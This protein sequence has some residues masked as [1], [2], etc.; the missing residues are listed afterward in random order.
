[1]SD[2]FVHPGRLEGCIRIPPSKSMAHRAVICSMLAG[3]TSLSG[4][5]TGAGDLGAAALS[6]DIHTTIEAMRCLLAGKKEISCDESGSTLRFLIPIAAALGKNVTFTGAGRLPD[7]PLHEYLAIFEDKGISLKFPEDGRSLPLSVKGQL[8]AGHFRVPG[9]VSSQYITGLLLALPLLDGDSEI[10]V[11]SFLESAGYVDM[12]LQVM[13][14]FGVAA[15]NVKNSYLIHGGQKYY[16]SSYNIEGDYSQAAFW[17]TANYLGS[18]VTLSGLDDASAQGDRDIIWFLEI[19]RNARIDAGKIGSEQADRKKAD[20]K[21]ADRKQTGGEQ[22]GVKQTGSDQTG[23]EIEIDASQ[24]PDLVPIIAVAA[25]NTDATTKIV[26]AGRLRYKESDRLKS[27]AQMIS[28]IGGDITETSDGLLIRGGRRMTGGTAD[29]YGD[30]RISMAAAI[31]A[32]STL[33]GVT[34]INYNCVD[35]SYPTFFDEFKK[36]GGVLN[37]LDLGKQS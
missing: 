7:R 37:E 25:A 33:N 12:T 18:D 22:T 13:K 10:E 32:L 4:I 30:H 15:S 16:K 26:N 28:G 8:T 11:T 23:I 34:I 17:L 36:T 2:L 19:F 1:M 21:Q 20:R 3:N 31:A 14:H 24:I 35:K 27:T 6:R 5:G 9:N 29:S